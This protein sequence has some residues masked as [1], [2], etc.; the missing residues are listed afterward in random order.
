MA[1][2]LNKYFIKED[3]IDSKWAYKT[4]A[5]YLSHKKIQIIT[6]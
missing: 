3:Y 5:Q 1:K 2:Y 4:I 6:K